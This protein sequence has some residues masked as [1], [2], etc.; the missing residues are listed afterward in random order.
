MTIYKK[1]VNYNY[2]YTTFIIIFLTFY[3][4]FIIYPFHFTLQMSNNKNNN[5]NNNDNF[6]G[7][8]LAQGQVFRKQQQTR[9]LTN[10]DVITG[11][12]A[13]DQNKNKVSNKNYSDIWPEYPIFTEGSYAQITNNIRYPN[14]PDNG[15][16]VRAEFS[17]AFYKNKPHKTNYS[18]PLEPVPLGP[19][20]RI[21]YYKTT[22]NLI[23]GASPEFL[24]SF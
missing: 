22:D 18:T 3:Y 5:D 17:N 6:L 7:P 15:T 11:N 20:M 2:K 1:Y 21:G 14:N 4:L 8:S 12:T 16:A 23:L 9:I 10:N 19:G 13:R 24:P